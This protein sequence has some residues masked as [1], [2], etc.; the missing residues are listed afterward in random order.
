MAA[1]VDWTPLRPGGFNF[2]THALVEEGPSRLVMRPTLGLR[3]F[4]LVF[5]LAGL[6]MVVIGARLSQWV[7]LVLGIPV[8]AA[9]AWVL[10]RKGGAA[11]DRQARA[12]VGKTSV[13]FTSI[14]ALQLIKEDVDGDFDSYE[15]NLVL[16]SG[17]RINVTDHSG[18]QQVKADAQR[19]GSFIGCKVWD[20]TAS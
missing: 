18:R 20:T 15:L 6:S 10:F 2:V 8:T 4:G 5:A 16:T 19:L 14:H 13:P 1:K 9:G 12:F 11:F 7:A 17:E 3:I